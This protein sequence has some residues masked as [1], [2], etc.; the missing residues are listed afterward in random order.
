MKLRRSTLL[1]VQLRT[2]IVIADTPLLDQDG[3]AGTFNCL[4]WTFLRLRKTCKHAYMYITSD[5]DS[6]DSLT[7]SLKMVLAG[8]A[9]QAPS[10][11]AGSPSDR[12][13]ALVLGRGD[14]NKIS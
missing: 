1:W 13:G 4:L 12:R 3:R 8:Q 9:D 2:K 5:S 10:R 11:G 7:V 14:F 6:D